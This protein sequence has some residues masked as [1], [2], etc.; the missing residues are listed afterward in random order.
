MRQALR[1]AHKYVSLVFLLFWAVQ[2][3]SG[4]FLVFHREIDEL[5][6]A[7]PAQAL[8]V[9]RLGSAVQRIEAQNPGMAASSIFLTSESGRHFDLML[10]D[11][12][13]ASHI[14]RLD[15]Q[16]RALLQRPLEAPITRGGAY[17]WANR[18]HRTLLAG[19]VGAWIVGISGVLLLTNLF[20]ALRI[21][22]PGFRQLRQAVLPKRARSAAAKL[23]S[24]HRALGLWLAPLALVTISCGVLLAFERGTERIVGAEQVRPPRVDALEAGR[25]VSPAEAISLALKRFPASEFSGAI[26]P[27][28]SRSV[29]QIFL[30]QPG[31][32]RQ[33]HGATRVYVSAR[34]GRIARAYDPLKAPAANRFMDILFPIHTGQ[35]GGTPTRLLVLIIGVWLLTMIGLGLA[36]WNSR[37]KLKAKQVSSVKHKERRE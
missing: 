5:A 18:L 4:I 9:N 8:D 21:A 17:I 12:T 23:F 3:L 27:S 2:A 30:R 6:T 13:G 15:G 25:P 10:E 29:Y 16:G 37:R 19:S 36:L 7:A 33:T 34:S 22:W 35:I 20:V 11:D 28:G 24:L 26:L 1:K 14:V 31:E 32:A